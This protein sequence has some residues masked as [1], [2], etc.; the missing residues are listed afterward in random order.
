[1]KLRLKPTILS[2]N[3]TGEV[4][5][6]I[7]GK[8][9]RI[10]DRDG[11]MWEL[12][13]ALDGTRTAEGV[14]DLVCAKHPDAG[15]T[16]VAAMV[17]EFIT[18]RMVEIPEEELTTSLSPELRSRFSRNFDFFGS[19]AAF[20]ENKYS[21]QERILEARICV[22]GCGGLG[23]HILFELAAVGA[24]HLTILDF[25]RIELSNLN[26]Q[27]LYKEADIGSVKVETAKRRL[28][29]F[30]SGLDIT[31][32]HR[33]LESTADVAA[34]IQGHDLVICIADKPANSMMDWLNAACVACRVP[35]ITGG[36]DIRRSVFFSVQPGQSGCA[37]CWF[38]AARAKNALDRE[39]LGINK[40]QD[41]TYERPAPAFVPLVAVTAGLMV[42]EG[43][44]Y[45]TRCQPPQLTNKLKEFSFDDMS[46]NVAETWARDPGCR[47]CGGGRT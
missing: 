40:A 32:H 3:L 11:A 38:T 7:G 27:I 28:L 12:T 5:L 25:D 13:R 26:R 4:V 2:Y 46:L 9:A 6:Q 43:V 22:L 29:E 31:T 20:G 10:P 42:S 17:D 33:R 18:H 8:Y 23:T 44:R 41:V 47:I 16:R 34:V 36:L 39:V 45:I 37:E 21:Y 19:L 24:R 1:M 35:F 14:T 30:N 15:R